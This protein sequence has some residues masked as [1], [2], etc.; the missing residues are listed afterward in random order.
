[1]FY[2]FM[3]NRFGPDCWW[4][5]S[6]MGGDVIHPGAGLDRSTY[7]HTDWRTGRK[8]ELVVVVSLALRDF[9]MEMA[10]LELI[11]EA[12][13]CWCTPL[14]RKGELLVRNADT[15]HRG[16]P[17]TSDTPRC[18]AAMRFIL[19]DALRDGYRPV[20]LFPEDMMVWFPQPLRGICDLLVIA[21]DRTPAP[22]D[23]NNGFE[24]LADE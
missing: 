7:P 18:L 3:V 15:I 9:T 13:G 8:S 24:P 20:P 23:E 6:T 19:S 12:T 4:L 2:I 10:P 5:D 21:E 22:I 16:S 17:N 11:S 14:L 1:M